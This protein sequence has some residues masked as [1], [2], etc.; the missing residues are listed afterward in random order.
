MY[1]APSQNRKVGGFGFRTV[2]G[3]RAPVRQLMINQSD[4]TRPMVMLA[5]IQAMEVVVASQHLIARGWQGA[6]P[7]C[8]NECSSSGGNTSPWALRPRA[9]AST[10]AGAFATCWLL[11]RFHL[12][13]DA[14][15]CGDLLC[16]GGLQDALQSV[17]WCGSTPHVDVHR[18]A[19]RPTGC[20]SASAVRLSAA[21]I[22]GIEWERPR[23]ACLQARRPNPCVCSRRG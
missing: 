21:N 4:P 16:L 14:A 8:V 7:G 17:G 13:A 22:P 19:L 15:V 23:D 1:P 20:G 11:D 6:R 5:R 18:A 3:T 12:A 10:G 9:M 2:R